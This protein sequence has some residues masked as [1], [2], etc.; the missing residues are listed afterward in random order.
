MVQTIVEEK[1]I[2]VKMLEELDLPKSVEEKVHKRYES[3]GKWFTR[4]E[5]TLKDV[6]IFVQGSFGQGTTIK[7]L[8]EGEE[9]DLDM[10][11]KV[12]ISKFIFRR[13]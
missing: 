5:S 4:D 3:L 13:I 2:L 7:P 8:Q 11:C 6:D 9:Y 10:S 1:M 12:N